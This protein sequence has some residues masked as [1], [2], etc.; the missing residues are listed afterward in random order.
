LKEEPDG[1]VVIDITT[2]D[3][4]SQNDL[5]NLSVKFDSAA[6]IMFS[7]ELSEPLI[8]RL[9]VEENFSMVLKDASV[10]EIQLAISY[11][12]KGDRYLCHQITN[13]LLTPS[14]SSGLDEK[15]T[16]S[17]VDIL[18]LIAAGKSV[19][20]IAYE[21]NSSIHTITTHKKNIFRKL[22][23]NTVY[24]ATKWALKSGLVDLVEYYI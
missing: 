23:V 16:K 6:W 11:A 7:E 2:F 13:I 15:L 9:S 4:G 20:E 22:G 14:L 24:E 10:N 5:L 21:R 17:E 8:R 1:I 3:I 12:A 18:K 19:K